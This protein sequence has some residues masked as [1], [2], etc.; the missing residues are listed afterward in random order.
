MGKKYMERKE[1]VFISLSFHV[2]FSHFSP[3]EKIGK[4]R[5]NTFFH[6]QKWGWTPSPQIVNLKYRGMT[7]FENTV[8][9]DDLDT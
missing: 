5:E 7:H 8:H 2:L 3:W 6:G 4:E 1:K 9:S